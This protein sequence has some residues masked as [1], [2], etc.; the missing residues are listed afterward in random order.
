MTAAATAQERGH[1]QARV[2]PAKEAS[3]VR[4]SF[5][6][7]SSTPIIQNS[8]A[9]KPL[10]SPTQTRTSSRFLECPST[11]LLWGCWHKHLYHQTHL[12]Q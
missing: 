11:L 2:S 10:M 8:L 5:I 6:Q 9:S 4:S 7:A 1:P 12:W 3:G